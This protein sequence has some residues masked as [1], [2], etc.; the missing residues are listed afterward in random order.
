MDKGF[1]S[2]DVKDILNL[3]EDGFL[4]ERFGQEFLSARLGYKFLSSGGIKDRGIDGLEYISES[5]KSQKSIFQI[6]IDK[7]PEIKIKHTVQKLEDN[8]I[9]FSRLTYLTNVQIKNKDKLID[10]YIEQKGIIL[11]IFDSSWIAD[12]ANNSEATKSVIEN[13]IKNHLRK[14]QK[15]GEGLIVNDY[16]VNPNLYVYLMHQIGRSEDIQ[17]LNQDLIDTLILYSLRDTDPDQSIF[18]SSDAIVSSVKELLNFEIEKIQTKINKRLK[19]LSKKSNKKVNHHT[20]INKYCLPYETRL[21][22]VSNNAK[23]KALYDIFH[24]EA[25]E[26]IKKNLKAKSV[27][28]RDISTLLH[29]I[30]EKIFYRQG[31]EFS[32]FLLNKGCRDT[33]EG[34][35]SDTVDEILD[36]SSAIDKNRSQIKDALIVSIRQLIYHGSKEAKQYLYSLSKTYLMLFLLKCDPNIV[37]F[38]QTMAGNLTI[39]V[40]TSVLVPAFSEI[41]L[42]PQNQRYWS[43]LKSAKSK[44]VNLVI[45]DTIISELDFHIKRSKYLFDTEYKNHIDFYSDGAEDLVDQILVRAYIYA[46]KEGNATTYDKFI[47]NFITIDGENTKQELIDFLYEEFG[48]QYIT[49]DDIDVEIDKNGFDDLVNELAEFKKSRDKA[50]SDANLILTIYAIRKKYGEEKSSLDGYK[51]WWLSSDTMTHKSVCKIFKE[52]YPVSCYMRPDFLYNYISFTPQ[53]EAVAEVYKKTF[54]NLL[55]M[56]ISNH[57]SHDISTSIRK[58]IQDHSE[59]MDGRVKAKIRNLVDKL[60]SNPEYHYKEELVSFFQ[61]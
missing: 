20:D 60:K 38:F 16:L 40:C 28:V 35:L 18:L 9:S 3:I 13:F 21:Q 47:D 33:F 14:Y 49:K 43:L 32:D 25:E 51:T 11:R 6:S 7:K 10:Q 26:V 57:I 42:E 58:M 53:K 45:N 23:D 44:G 22:I 30:L 4:F 2:S 48:I 39:F 61:D 15:P 24:L 12:N 46:L 5:D 34:N 50:I 59:K 29:K 31:L 17:N 1:S 36:E 56:H 27:G 8:K 55:G 54:P 37:D 41:Y 52:K 19:Q